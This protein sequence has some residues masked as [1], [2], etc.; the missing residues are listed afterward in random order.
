MA[1]VSGGTA[2]ERFGFIQRYRE[3]G[4]TPLCRWLGVSASGF[5]AWLARQPSQRLQNDQELL[6]TITTIYWASKGRYGS[7]RVHMALQKQGIRV[8]RKRVERLMREAGLRGR[9][10]K[11]TRRQP[12]LKRF[13]ASGDNLL[14]RLNKP[15][16]INQVWVG[17]VTYLKVGNQWQYLATVMDLYS[18]RILAWSLSR[19]RTT[20]LTAGIFIKALKRRNYPQGLMFHSDRGIEYTAFD[21]R[22][23][24]KAHGVRQSFNRPGHCTDNAYMESFFHSLKAELIRG[25]NFELHRKLRNALA[26]YINHFYNT[27][28]LHSGLEYM[29]PIEYEQRAA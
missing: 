18:R 19:T 3:L 22:K 2:S 10:V 12:G 13:K 4:V 6:E 9:V 14:I 5:Y 27:V 29:S 15:T 1:T 23:L 26:G 17:D 16:G 11:V 8:G 24:L 7:P 20:D 28:R 21:Y 25:S